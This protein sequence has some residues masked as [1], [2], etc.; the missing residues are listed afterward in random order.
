MPRCEIHNLSYPDRLGECPRCAT[1]PDASGVT[2]AQRDAIDKV[3]ALVNAAIDRYT[4][5]RL[6]RTTVLA[7]L[8]ALTVVTETA[9]L[10]WPQARRDATDRY[11]QLLQ[12]TREQLEQAQALESPAND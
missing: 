5:D 4:S 2:G 1:E 10:F 7:R 6:V 9:H 11:N 8:L 12:A 3:S